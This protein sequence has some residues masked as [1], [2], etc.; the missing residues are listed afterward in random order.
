MSLEDGYAEHCARAASRS[1][2]SVVAAGLPSGVALITTDQIG[3]NRIVVV[4]GANGALRPRDIDDASALLA[5]AAMILTQLELETPFD[6]IEYLAQQA[7]GLRVPLILDPAPARS[8][9]ARLLRL[10]TDLTPNESE[11][12]ALCNGSGKLN[13]S[14]AAE[15]ARMLRDRGPRNMIVKMGSQGVYVSGDNFEGLV[16]E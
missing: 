5:S 13:P 10:V 9:P 1:V 16:P 12:M 3:Q 11:S 7:Q 8:L 2:P 14:T 4:P 6:T 15:Q